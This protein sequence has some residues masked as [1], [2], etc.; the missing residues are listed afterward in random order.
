MRLESLHLSYFLATSDTNSPRLAIY[1][2]ISYVLSYALYLLSF[3]LIENTVRII[4]NFL[5]KYLV[6]CQDVRVNLSKVQW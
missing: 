4:I 5:G 3:L 1:F 6:L 2:C